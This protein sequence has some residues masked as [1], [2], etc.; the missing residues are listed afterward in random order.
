MGNVSLDSFASSSYGTGFDMVSVSSLAFPRLRTIENLIH[1]I[2]HQPNLG[3]EAS[4]SLIELGE[5]VSATA[6]EDEIAILLRG[7]LFQESYVRNS[8]LQ[9]LQVSS[10]PVPRGVTPV[11]NFFTALRP[12][13]HGLVS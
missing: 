13:R 1:V 8:C 9:T 5:A 3:K 7:T 10:D 6:T 11:T 12:Y 2:R 4:S